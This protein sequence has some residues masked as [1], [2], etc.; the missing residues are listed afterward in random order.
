MSTA[1]VPLPAGR[2]R[3]LRRP[4]LPDFARAAAIVVAGAVLGSVA[5]ALSPAP[6]NVF[7]LH[8]PGAPPE[9][10]PRVTVEKFRRWWKSRA[11]GGN[12]SLLIL[13]ARNK[14]LFTEG[15]APGAVLMPPSPAEEFAAAWRAAADLLED[16]ERVVIVCDSEACRRADLLAKKLEAFG[17]R[18][19]VVLEGG[20]EAYR[21]AG[22]PVKTGARP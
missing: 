7:D 5:D 1:V 8:G 21:A 3:R 22:L 4:W 12:R 20:W 9:K 6:L 14:E 19:S 18:H 10:A 17:V 13:D 2:S 11:V 16:A 15:H